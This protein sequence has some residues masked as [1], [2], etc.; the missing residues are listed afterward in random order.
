MSMACVFSWW[1]VGHRVEPAGVQGMATEHA[2]RRKPAALERAEAGDGLHGVF[3]A[4]GMESAT[5]TEQ[6][7]DPALVAAQR[8]DEEAVDHGS[9]MRTGT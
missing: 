4:G 1:G 2:P 5:R 6:W 7:T 9:L 8:D 3:G